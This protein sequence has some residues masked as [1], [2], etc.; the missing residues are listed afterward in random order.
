MSLSRIMYLDLF[1][2]KLIIMANRTHSSGGKDTN[3]LRR[4]GCGAVK[5][6]SPN[7]RLIIRF[8]KCRSR[9][10]KETSGVLLLHIFI[11]NDFLPL[12]DLSRIPAVRDETHINQGLKLA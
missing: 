3:A 4:E 7:E 9:L 5:F 2:L 11:M 10:Y 1:S 8:N 12:G 6:L